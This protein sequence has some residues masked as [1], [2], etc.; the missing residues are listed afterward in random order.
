MVEEGEGPHLARGE[1]SESGRG[2]GPHL[3]AERGIA[4][5]DCI[6]CFG[7]YDLSQRLPRRLNCGHTFCQ[8][9]LSRLDTVI[10]EQVWL[11]CPQCRQNTPCPRGGPAHLDLDLHC[12]LTLRDTRPHEAGPRVRSDISSRVTFD[13]AGF[14][15]A[16]L[17][18]SEG[19]EAWPGGP[20]ET[21]L[22]YRL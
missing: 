21:R 20:P 15:G 8:A 13:E 14:K 6:V 2:T 18:S 16:E 22:H 5:R 12:F 11:P 7:A 9:C 3:E 10:N 17:E 4:R 1:E 19:L